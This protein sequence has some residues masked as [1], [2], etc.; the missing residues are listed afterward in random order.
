[1]NDFESMIV[2]QS[3]DPDVLLEEWHLILVVLEELDKLF[4]LNVIC[5][6]FKH[7]EW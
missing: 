5:S 1:M 3:C 4:W 2:G 6:D 7:S